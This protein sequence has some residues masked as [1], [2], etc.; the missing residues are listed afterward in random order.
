M[1]KITPIPLLLGIEHHLRHHARVVW[2]LRNFSVNTDGQMTTLRW[3]ETN[4]L[5]RSISVMIQDDP[6]YERSLIRLVVIRA[7]YRYRHQPTLGL[8]SREY[9]LQDQHII[10]AQ[11][12]RLDEYFRAV[13]QWGPE[14]VM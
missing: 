7:Y 12:L 5:E 11:G 10:W 8:R 1:S 6:D 13:I 2:Q 9:D 14:D 4:N 3:H